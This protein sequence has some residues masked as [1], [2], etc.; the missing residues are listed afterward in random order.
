VRNTVRHWLNRVN[1]RGL[2]GLHDDVRTGRPPTGS[3]AKFVI[4]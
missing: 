2:D 1:A 3:V 4:G